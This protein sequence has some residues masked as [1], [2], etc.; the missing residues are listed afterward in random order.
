[1]SALS[2]RFPESGGSGTCASF[3]YLVLGGKY[4]KCSSPILSKFYFLNCVGMYVGISRTEHRL[5]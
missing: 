2:K 5:V 3:L 1:M 4:N